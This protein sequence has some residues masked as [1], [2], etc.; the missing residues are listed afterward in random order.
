[1][2]EAEEEEVKAVPLPQL[3]ANSGVHHCPP[4][5]SWKHRVLGPPPELGGRSRV[6]PENVHSCSF[7]GDAE[8]GTT[9]RAGG[10]SFSHG[11]CFKFLKRV[12]IT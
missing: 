5:G 8:P 10:P 4:G 2:N 1:M 6:G 11:Q 9:L 12:N 3:P 7:P